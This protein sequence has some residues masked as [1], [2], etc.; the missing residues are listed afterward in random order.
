MTTSGAYTGLE[1][2]VNK[3]FPSPFESQILEFWRKAVTQY[4]KV[5]SPECLGPERHQ[6]LGLSLKTAF[7]LGDTT[8]LLKIELRTSRRADGAL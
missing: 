5:W 2:H 4:V 1:V 7:H 6:L 3:T 8:R